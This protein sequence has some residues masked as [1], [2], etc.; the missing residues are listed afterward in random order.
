MRGACSEAVPRS[1]PVLIDPERCE[2]LVFTY[3]EGLLSP[4]AHDLQLRVT[5]FT[6]EV[7]GETLRARFD[8][9]S[10]EVVCAM[11]DGQP[12]PWILSAADKDKI[13]HTIRDEVL[14]SSLHRE[15]AFDS[16]SVHVTTDR[17][18]VAGKLK[19]HGRT[20]EL[21]IDATRAADG[22]YVAQVSLH[23]PDF[24]ITPYKA[25]LGALRVKPAV[26]VRVMLPAP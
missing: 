17:A 16:T 25:M 10:L 4:V 14:D 19:L 18:Q 21:T 24:G 11:R 7:E 26:T 3:K 20:R 9:S 13:A 1:L 23:Q 6:V 12:A 5:R 2:C 15:I 8:A 22:R